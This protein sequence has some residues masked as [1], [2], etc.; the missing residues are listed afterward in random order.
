MD[1]LPGAARIRALA[2]A[3]SPTLVIE[4]SAIDAP[5]HRWLRT[6]SGERVPYMHRA[7]VFAAVAQLFRV[8][9]DEQLALLPVRDAA[10]FWNA[11]Y[12]LGG[13][14]N[15]ARH[16]GSLTLCVRDIAPPPPDDVDDDDEEQKAI[17]RRTMAAARKRRRETAVLHCD[18]LKRQLASM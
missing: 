14:R 12:Q 15:M 13:A 5:P 11:V 17:G 6:P 7:A 8:D 16:G 10:L 2:C 9:N 3:Q 18:R 4:R 1:A